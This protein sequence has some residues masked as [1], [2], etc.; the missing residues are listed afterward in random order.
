MGD[1]VTGNDL[2]RVVF[3]DL[4]ELS[5]SMEADGYPGTSVLHAAGGLI[6]ALSQM[7]EFGLGIEELPG[8]V[9]HEGARE[10]LK[11]EERE[12]PVGLD[13][14]VIIDKWLQV[15]GY[16]DAVIPGAACT[17]PTEDY[18]TVMLG[19]VREIERLRAERKG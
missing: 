18:R 1:D 13:L 3:A 9:R 7:A 10:W 2:V 12:T 5:E 4:A 8:V 15:C 11:S 16:C 19:L 6:F 14:P 17:H